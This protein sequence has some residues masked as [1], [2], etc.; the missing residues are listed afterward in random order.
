MQRWCSQKIHTYLRNFISSTEVC[1]AI[2]WLQNFNAA[3]FG[4]E[5]YLMVF[6][7]IISKKYTQLV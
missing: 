1:I 5:Q 6:I 4:S 3:E 7:L 2:F